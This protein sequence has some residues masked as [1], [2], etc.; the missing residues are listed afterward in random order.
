VESGRALDLRDARRRD[1]C[2]CAIS[3]GRAAVSASK[4]FAPGNGDSPHHALTEHTTSSELRG[5]R[6]LIPLS[7]LRSIAVS[8]APPRVRS[9]MGWLRTPASR[10][11][12]PCRF[13]AGAGAKSIENQKARRAMPA[14]RSFPPCGKW[15]GRRLRP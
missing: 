13:T 14:V 1:S 11:R 5:R 8:T 10:R 12:Q 4:C 9:A 3:K 15:G 6:N 2:L 7:A